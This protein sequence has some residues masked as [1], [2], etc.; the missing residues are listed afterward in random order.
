MFNCQ[1]QSNSIHGL[2]YRYIKTCKK[3]TG[4]CLDTSIANQMNPKQ[5]SIELNQTP[6]VQLLFDWFSNPV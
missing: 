3:V 1:T 4:V 2:S 5:K 6:I